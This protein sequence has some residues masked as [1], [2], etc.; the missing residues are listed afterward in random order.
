MNFSTGLYRLRPECPNNGYLSRNYKGL[1]PK[2]ATLKNC[3]DFRDPTNE[4]L[5]IAQDTAELVNAAK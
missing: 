5:M 1:S 4:E 2:N 3:R